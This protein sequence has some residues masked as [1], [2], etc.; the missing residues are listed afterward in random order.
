MFPRMPRSLLSTPPTL[1]QDSGV[2]IHH[3]SDLAVLGCLGPRDLGGDTP[4]ASQSLW[5]HA[6]PPLRL[7][8]CPR[9][10]HTVSNHTPVT[11]CSRPHLLKSFQNM[12]TCHSSTGHAPS[13]RTASPGASILTRMRG[14]GGNRRARSLGFLCGRERGQGHWCQ[15]WRCSAGPTSQV[16][17]TGRG[18]D[19]TVRGHN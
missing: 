4:I 11:L 17:V 8:T 9:V 13:P 18:N 7:Q 2:V 12:P 19:V 14:M 16:S 1:H 10:S 6:H 5:G 15:S 3:W